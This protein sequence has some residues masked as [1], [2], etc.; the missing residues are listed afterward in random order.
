M[1]VYTLSLWKKFIM[2]NPASAGKTISMFF[3]FD[4]T[5]PASSWMQK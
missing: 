1:L 5:C 2:H 4:E 3:T